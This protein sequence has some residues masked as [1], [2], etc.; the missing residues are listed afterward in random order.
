M[1]LSYWESIAYKVNFDKSGL[2]PVILGEVI[3]MTSLF[4]FIYADSDLSCDYSNSLTLSNASELFCG[5]E[6]LRIISEREKKSRRRLVTPYIK[7]EA[8]AFVRHSWQ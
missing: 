7:H 4:D 1:C 5:V 8:D 3:F 2:F 6:F